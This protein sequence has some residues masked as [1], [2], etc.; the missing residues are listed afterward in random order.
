MRFVGGG[1]WRRRRVKPW[2]FKMEKIG[3]VVEI[4]D[5]SSSF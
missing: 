3:F 4:H 5:I 1:G 2:K